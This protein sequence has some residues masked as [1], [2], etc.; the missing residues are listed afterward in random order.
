MTRDGDIYYCFQEKII[1]TNISDPE[2]K[3]EL[4]DLPSNNIREMIINKE[5][6][7]LYCG[8]EDGSIY[9]IPIQNTEENLVKKED[10]KLS[11]GKSFMRKTKN[12][13]GNEY[14]YSHEKYIDGLM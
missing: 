10:L 9:K 8:Y 11:K 12:T 1:K 3:K 2:S 7:F 13:I 6:T 14:L 4:S 5:E